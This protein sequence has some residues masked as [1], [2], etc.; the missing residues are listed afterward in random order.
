MVKHILL[1]YI[2]RTGSSYIWQLFKN[3]KGVHVYGEI[4]NGPEKYLKPLKASQ[5]LNI[6]DTVDGYR[7]FSKNLTAYL[8]FLKAESTEPYIFT[9]ISL[10][11]ISALIKEKSKII[12]DILADPNTTVIL[13]KR[14]LIDT[15][16]SLKKVGIT[17]AWRDCDTTDIKIN[18]DCDDFQDYCNRMRLLYENV[19]WMLERNKNPNFMILDYSEWN[20]DS[21]SGETDWNNLIKLQGYLIDRVA[22]R[23]DINIPRFETVTDNKSFMT[24]QDR[25]SNYR[26]KISNYHEFSQFI[27]TGNMSIYI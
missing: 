7:N 13:L 19:L 8:E 23:L 22:L 16:I 2:A 18:I 12:M 25:N 5:K 17:N 20:Q 6:P 3:F 21:Q 1:L 4:M 24:K 15:Y 11:H 27:Q 9:K 10:V 14:N 26:Q